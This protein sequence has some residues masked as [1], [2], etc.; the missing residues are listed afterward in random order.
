MMFTA[1]AIATGAQQ[2]YVPGY[3][4]ARAQATIYEENMPLVCGL[5][6]RG[7]TFPIHGPL[8]GS[9][10][11]RLTLT[12]N[13]VLSGMAIS[14][15]VTLI[16]AL[17]RPVA[18]P[19]VMAGALWFW[20]SALISLENSK[21]RHLHAEVITHL[22]ESIGLIADSNDETFIRIISSP[23]VQAMLQAIVDNP[24]PV[25]E[26]ASILASMKGSQRIEATKGIIG[27]LT[28]MDLKQGSRSTGERI[29]QRALN[30]DPTPGQKPNAT[31][32]PNAL[33]HLI[34][35]REYH[36]LA[37]LTGIVLAMS[38]QGVSS[39]AFIARP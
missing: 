34:K 39:M 30:I 33:Y 32:L 2:V 26:A 36:Y 37:L 29:L 22:R 8:V 35:G 28:L 25:L 6:A 12:S 21:N 19:L 16:P 20:K 1:A 13:G 17:I 10:M 31:G 38:T 15:G 5:I 24:S 11:D 27:A 3:T 4:L 9:F 18:M 14:T 23:E 7:Q